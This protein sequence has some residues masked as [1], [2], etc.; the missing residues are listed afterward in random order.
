MLLS[1]RW[2]KE[3][4]AIALEALKKHLKCD[5]VK[6]PGLYIHHEKPYLG[7]SP[8]GIFDCKCHTNS[9]VTIKCPFKYKNGLPQPD[10]SDFCMEMVEQRW[11]LKRNHIYYYQVQL[12]LEVCKMESCHFFVWTQ[13]AT[14]YERIERSQTFFNDNISKVEY[15]Y[16]YGILPELVG[17]FYSSIEEGDRGEDN[18]TGADD[19]DNNTGAEGQ[20]N[21]TG[22]EGQDNNTGAEGQDNNTGV[23][24]QDNNTGANCQ[25]DCYCNLIS[26]TKC[27]KNFH[28]K[29]LRIPNDMNEAARRT[30]KCPSCHRLK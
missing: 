12:Q 4:E 15:I 5:A 17:K 10:R 7:A 27:Y 21:N 16:K 30:W 23:E 14:A 11:Q 6:T 25:V 20:D 1:F 28:C 3:N 9:L 13:Q 26:C 19:Q 8:D 2:G 24:G 29:C 18:N 22:V